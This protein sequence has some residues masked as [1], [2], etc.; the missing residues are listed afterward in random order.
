[1]KR[2]ISYLRKEVVEAE[3]NDMSRTRHE[4][5]QEKYSDLTESDSINSTAKPLFS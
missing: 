1:M 5:N 3:E 4:V 2:Y